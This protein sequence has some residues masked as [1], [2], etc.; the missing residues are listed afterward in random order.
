M[1]LKRFAVLSSIILSAILLL[2][3]TIGAASLATASPLPAPD[4][5]PSRPQPGEPLDLGQ[6]ADVF[7]RPGWERLLRVDEID[8]DPSTE[9]PESISD[10]FIEFNSGAGGDSCF[11]PDTYQTFCFRAESQTNDYECALDQFLRFPQDWTITHAYDAGP[12]TCENGSFSEFGQWFTG[13]MRFKSTK[14]GFTP[15]PVTDA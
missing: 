3:V 9:G 8:L 6:G 1:H 2:V 14:T 4:D 11:M 15:I 12:T 7:V 10:S 13:R 5:S